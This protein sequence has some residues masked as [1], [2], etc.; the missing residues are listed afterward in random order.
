MESLGRAQNGSLSILNNVE[1]AE[2]DLR[3]LKP[4]LFQS[5]F[6]AEAGNEPRIAPNQSI[7]DFL[8][9]KKLG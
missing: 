7:L 6:V 1:R 2:A 4:I 9:I 3:N 8:L 5:F